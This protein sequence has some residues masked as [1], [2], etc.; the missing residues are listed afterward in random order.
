MLID[1]VDRILSRCT[2]V[3][4]KDTGQSRSRPTNLTELYPNP[5]LIPRSYG[6]RGHAL[7]DSAM[8]LV[9][10]AAKRDPAPLRR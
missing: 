1:S 10:Y 4:L 5:Q 8:E 7:L 3:T 6:L 9:L 2:R